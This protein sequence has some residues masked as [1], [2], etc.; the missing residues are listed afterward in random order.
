MEHVRL[1]QLI[2]IA[3]NINFNMVIC[4]AC[5]IWLVIWLE[6]QNRKCNIILYCIQICIKCISIHTE[7]LNNFG[8][9]RI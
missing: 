1:Y 2:E 9:M 3:F 5:G 7:I 6:P 4:K 8:D